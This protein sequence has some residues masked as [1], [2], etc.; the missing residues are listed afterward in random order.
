MRCPVTGDFRI[1]RKRSGAARVR[2]K[3]RTLGLNYGLLPL[4][5]YIY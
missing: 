4:F 2:G 5:I 1:L 3:L